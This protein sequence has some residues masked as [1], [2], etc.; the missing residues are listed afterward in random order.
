MNHEQG[1][2]LTTDIDTTS[3]ESATETALAEEAIRVA[4]AAETVPRADQPL[5]FDV[6]KLTVYYGTFRAVKDVDIETQVIRLTM[7]RIRPLS[8]TAAGEEPTQF[9]E[10]M[11]TSRIAPW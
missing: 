4:K 8:H 9:A 7:S 6:G 5:I 2:G 3:L 10:P 11:S 1:D